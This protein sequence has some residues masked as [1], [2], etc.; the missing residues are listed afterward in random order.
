MPTQSAIAIDI[1]S[2]QPGNTMSRWTADLAR[3]VVEAAP[4]RRF[5][6]LALRGSTSLAT[7]GAD[8]RGLDALPNVE[9]VEAPFDMTSH[10]AN[11]WFLNARLGPMLRRLG[12]GLYHGPAFHAPWRRIGV[13]TVVTIHDLTAFED[14]SYYPARFRLFMQWAIRLAARNASRVIAVSEAVRQD[15][16]RRLSL[17]PE[18]VVAIPNGVPSGVERPPS[19]EIEGFRRRMDLPE[20]YILGVGT[21]SARKNPTGL[22]R[23]L[24]KIPARERPLLVWAGADGHRSAPLREEMARRLGA[25][26]LRRI[27]GINDADLAL[28]MSGAAALAYPSFSEGFGLPVLEAM[29]LGVPVVCS[30][31]APHR[32]VAGDAALFADPRDPDALASRL[33][34]VLHDDSLRRRLIDAGPLRAERF[35]W[36]DSA[37]RVVGVYEELLQGDA[38]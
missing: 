11:E 9:I 23:A 20:R 13:P 14:R 32:E 12:A 1:R 7:G 22:A 4:E 36:T 28:L 34:D 3:H 25:A 6:L 24:E 5:F 26:G 16:L 17:P 2:I 29:A 18:R 8:L 35:R 37:R 30:D 15:I 19:E 31:I 10:P 21:L 33:L 38:R 27:T